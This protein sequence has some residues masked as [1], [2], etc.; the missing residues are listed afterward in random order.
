M[1]LQSE[2]H[3]L[4]VDSEVLCG[5]I[6]TL[7]DRGGELSAATAAD[8]MEMDSAVSTAAYAELQLATVMQW[9]Q[10]QRTTILLEQFLTS[11]DDGQYTA[12]LLGLKVCIILSVLSCRQCFDTVG[13]SSGGASGP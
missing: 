10:Q 5:S 2:M 11:D 12:A 9:S 8:M 13:W 3:S 1:N 4:P 6:S 7:L